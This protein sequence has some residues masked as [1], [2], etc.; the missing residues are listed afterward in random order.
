MASW[1][2][3]LRAAVR[4][5]TGGRNIIEKIDHGKKVVEI[6]REV[7]EPSLLR[8]IEAAV[9]AAASDYRVVQLT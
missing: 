1:E 5:V 4:Q 7:T 8:G 9:K 2:P 6:S 3:V